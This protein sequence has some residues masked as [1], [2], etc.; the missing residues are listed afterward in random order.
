[1]RVFPK[2][3][4]VQ[5]GSEVV[6]GG[7]PVL[8]AKGSF[9]GGQAPFVPACASQVRAKE[10]EAVMLEFFFCVRMFCVRSPKQQPAPAPFQQLVSAIL[11]PLG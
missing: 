4:Q 7:R 2:P 10:K 9:C 5:R 3:C 1:M 8:L 11:I 6:A